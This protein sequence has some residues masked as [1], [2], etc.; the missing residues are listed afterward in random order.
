MGVAERGEENGRFH[1]H[2]LMY[3]PDGEMVGNLYKRKDYSKKLGAVKETISNDFFEKRFGRND[4]EEI[5]MNVHGS[6]AVNYCLKYMRKTNCRAIYSRGVPSE[7][8]MTLD[9]DYDFAC[10]L[11]VNNTTHDYSLDRW[12]IWDSRVVYERDVM[13]STLSIRRLC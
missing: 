3:I 5:I 1:Y 11:T 12:V 2:F 10:S 6:Q 8:E 9:K 13:P 7:I 4:F